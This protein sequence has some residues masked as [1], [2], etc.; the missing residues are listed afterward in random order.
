MRPRKCVSIHSRVKSFG[1]ERTKAS[2]PRP[3]PST[4]PNQVRNV[5]SLRASLSRLETSSHRLSA[6][7][8]I[9]CSTRAARS[10][11]DGKSREH[12]SVPEAS[13]RPCRRIEGAKK[14]RNLQH[15]LLSL[16]TRP[17]DSPQL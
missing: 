1:T 4:S 14:V 7:S 5:V 15:F 13:Q 6:V 11:S 10:C 8:S 3:A 2:S 16:E 17:H 12:S 9:G